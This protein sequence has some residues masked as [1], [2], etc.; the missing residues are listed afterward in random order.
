MGRGLTRGQ[1]WRW[2][3]D[4][5][6]LPVVDGACRPVTTAVGADATQALGMAPFQAPSAMALVFATELV[7]LRRIVAGGGRVAHCGQFTCV[8]E[9]ELPHVSI[10]PYPGMFLSV[11]DHVKFVAPPPRISFRGVI[12]VISS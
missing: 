1:G 8:K 7:A 10:I 9:L 5:G 6:F 2:T 3:R 12:A 11:V 4:W